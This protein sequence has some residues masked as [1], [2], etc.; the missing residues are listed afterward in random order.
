[1]LPEEETVEEAIPQLL[2]AL[3]EGMGWEFGAFWTVGERS[4][5]RCRE[6]WTVSGLDLSSFEAATRASSSG[7][8]VG[9]PGRVW[10]SERPAFIPELTADP[11]FPLAA[12][13]AEAGLTVAVGLP[14]RAA[15]L[16]AG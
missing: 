15:E 7:P 11:D 8:G 4:V 16:C 1:M 3:G 5:L 2:R 14:L 10:A 9:L 6:T 13:A 12:A